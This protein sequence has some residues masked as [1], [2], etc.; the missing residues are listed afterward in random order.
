MAFKT[1]QTNSSEQGELLLAEL[2][3][4][5]LEVESIGYTWQENVG[6]KKGKGMSGIFNLFNSRKPNSIKSDLS[7]PQGCWRRLK[8]HSRKD[9]DLHSREKWTTS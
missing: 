6:E 5:F 8:L 3:R 7:Q 1:S 2:G 4:N 9:N